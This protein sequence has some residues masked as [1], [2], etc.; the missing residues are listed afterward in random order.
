[1]PTLT[2]HLAN[3]ISDG[4]IVNMKFQRLP[5]GSLLLMTPTET[6]VV[7][8]CTYQQ[9]KRKGSNAPA[10][11]STRRRSPQEQAQR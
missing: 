2:L 11:S 7:L 8:A 5:N 9:D 6:A 10:Q 3:N 4:D 1:M